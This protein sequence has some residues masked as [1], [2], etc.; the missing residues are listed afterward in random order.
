LDSKAL[1]IR[2][3]FERRHFNS[4]TVRGKAIFRP[5]AAFTDR[6]YYEGSVSYGGY[7]FTLLA[8]L[9]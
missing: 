6:I 3:G 4:L 8:Q 2:L 7:N 5:T 1:D 9:F